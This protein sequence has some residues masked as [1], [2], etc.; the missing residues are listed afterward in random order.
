MIKAHCGIFIIV[1]VV[2]MLGAARCSHTRTVSL[3]ITSNVLTP[4]KPLQRPTLSNT[5]LDNVDGPLASKNHILVYIFFILWPK[6][7]DL[8]LTH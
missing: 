7:I 6:L 4:V 3:T 5:V 8:E 2:R 1:L